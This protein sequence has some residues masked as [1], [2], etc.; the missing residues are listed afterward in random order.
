MSRI[1]RSERLGR[2]WEGI[3][4]DGSSRLLKN[5]VSTRDL[6]RLHT[7]GTTGEHTRRIAARDGRDERGFEVKS[8]KFSEL[9]TANFEL[10]IALLAR[11]A[12]KK[13]WWLAPRLFIIPLFETRLCGFRSLA[14]KRQGF[15]LKRDCQ[16][17]RSPE[18]RRLTPKP[19]NALSASSYD[20]WWRVP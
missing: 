5:Y 18:S 3:K 6:D 1:T 13:L 4:V 10:R 15:R 20:V 14:W 11:L 9:R 17:H 7:C 2:P 8:L 12:S 19:S 16:R